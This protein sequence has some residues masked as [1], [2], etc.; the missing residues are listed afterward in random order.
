MT[1]VIDAS[2]ALKWVIEEPDTPS[3]R[4]LLL[5]HPLA[6]PGFLLLE[7]ANA[8]W[9]LVR[10]RR[11]ER[12]DATVALSAIEAVSMQMFPTSRYVD[13]AQALPLDLG[14]TVYD[15]LYLAVAL[16]EGATLVTAD[17]AFVGAV[18]R[19]GGYAAAIRPLQG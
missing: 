18:Q 17:R 13:A 15:S 2:V 11:I 14:Q 3:A 5:D 6:A 12:N 10:R 7:C 9:A 1:L 19:H 4:E 8:L 16:A